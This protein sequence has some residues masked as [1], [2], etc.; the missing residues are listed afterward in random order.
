MLQMTPDTEMMIRAAIDVNI[1]VDWLRADIF[2]SKLLTAVRKP[3]LRNSRAVKLYIKMGFIW[4][5]SGI[6]FYS[7]LAISLIRI[8]ELVISLIRIAIINNLLLI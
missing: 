7:H 3:I 2:T 4:L 5:A 8:S 1:I 6:N